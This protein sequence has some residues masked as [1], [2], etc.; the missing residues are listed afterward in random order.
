MEIN[1]VP[2]NIFDLVLKDTHK[3][4]FGGN[5]DHSF[6]R[7]DFALAI[8]DNGLPVSYSLIQE[9][10]A[11]TVEMSYAGVVPEVRGINSKEI[12]AMCMNDLA[13]DYHYAVFQTEVTNIPMQRLALSMGAMITGVIKS[14]NN[15]DYVTMR[16]TLR[17]EK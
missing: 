8:T 4:V 7:Y 1:R 10:N 5:L 13:R 14:E 2:R 3:V 11:D 17:G 12:F 9:R 15:K 16:F 6:F